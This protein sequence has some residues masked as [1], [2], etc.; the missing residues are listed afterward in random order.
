M[1]TIE[2]FYN[3]LNLYDVVE[4][5][6]LPYYQIEYDKFNYTNV[7]YNHYIHPLWDEIGSATLFNKVLYADY[8]RHFAVIELLGEWNDCL[9][10]DIMYLKRN[11]L[12]ILMNAGIN[13]FV[14]IGEHVFNFHYSDDEYYSEWLEEIDDGWIVGINFRQHVINEFK[15]IRLNRILLFISEFGDFNWRKFSPVQLYEHIDRVLHRKLLI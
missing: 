2:P 15:Q 4:D 8:E 6:M 11:L 14:L 13:K 12:E 1:H 9:Y 10:N 5:K 3:W 7:I